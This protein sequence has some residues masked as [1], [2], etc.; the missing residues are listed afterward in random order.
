MSWLWWNVPAMAVFFAAWT[1]IPLYMVL[2]DPSWG[3]DRRASVRPQ[4]TV[5]VRRD[6]RPTAM[7]T[8]SMS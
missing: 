4:E 6:V 1:G 5:K 3:G 8:S 2:K 7:P